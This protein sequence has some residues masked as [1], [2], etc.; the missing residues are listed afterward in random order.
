M[1]ILLHN[2]CTEE[3]QSELSLNQACL[4]DLRTTSPHDDKDRIERTNGGLLK[5]SYCWILDNKQFKQWR[6]NRSSSLLWIRGDPGKGKTMLLCGV[7]EELTRSSGENANISFFF[8][9][10]TDVR[11]NN[12]TAVLRG[13]IYSLVEKQTSLLFH[14][15]CRYDQAGKALF[16]DINAL[17]ALSKIFKDILKDPTLQNTYLV[18]DALDECTTGLPF[19]L[20]LIDQE[21]SAHSHV[22]WIV[23]SRNWPDIEERLDAA[24]QRAPISL[25]LNEASVSDA[26]RKFI[27]HK[28]QQL[29]KVKNYSDEIRDAVYRHLY[30]NSQGT[31]LW[32]ALVCQDLQRT[33]RLHVLRRL[34]AFPPGLDALYGRMIDQVRKSEDADL[35]KQILAAML[36][37]YRPIT[38][39][40]LTALVELPSYIP[41]D[42]EAF[43]QIIST[44]GSFL[45]LRENVIIFV[46]QSAKEFL[47]EKVRIEVFLQ[48]KEA[49]HIQIFSRSLQI[50]FKTLRRN[51]SDISF[52]G[53]STEESTQLG[54]NALAAAKFSCQYWVDHLQEGWRGQD[55]YHSLDD[56][57]CVDQF[58]RE[59]FLH[60]L[61][62]LAILGSLTQG[63]TAMLK[64]E[65]LLQALLHRVQDSSQFIRYY[66]EAIQSS[67]LQI[68][69]SGL[70]FSPTRSITRACYQN[71][72]PDWISNCPGV[73]KEW[74]ACLHT[75]EGHS[76][77]VNSITWSN[78]GKRLASASHD[79]T[80]KIWDSITGQC[81]STLKGH[82]GSVYSVC[83]SQD[84]SRLV[85]SSHDKTVRIWDLATGRCV[86]ILEGHS[87]QV[88]SAFWSQD[89]SLLAS[90]SSDTT[91]RI[92]DPVNGN[93]VFNL[94]GHSAPVYSI[95]WQ[96]YGR[97]LASISIDKDVRIWDTDTGE[98]LFTIKD[99]C[100]EGDNDAVMSIA[101]LLNESRLALVSGKM[102]IRIWDLTTGKCISILEG[103]HSW[104][105]SMAWSQDGRRLASASHDKTVR[106]WD[107]ATGQCKLI[108]DGHTQPVNSVAWSQDGNRL[109]SA[110][111]DN[112][113]KIWDPFNG[114]IISTLE[115]HSAPISSICWPQ[116][117]RRL[118]SASFDKTI[119][120][121]NPET[122][123]LAS[124]FERHIDEII[125]IL[126]SQDGSRIASAS[127]DRTV[128]I[129]DPTSGRCILTIRGHSGPI[130]SISWSRDGRLLA[131]G[132][133]DTTVGI[134][135]SVTGQR[136]ST[137]EGHSRQV[138]SVAWSKDGSRLVSTSFDNTVRIWDPCS[139]Q[140]ILI[141]ERHS[142]WFRSLE[143]SQDGSR[144][145]LASSDNSI[146][147]F[148]P[149]T[150][151][152]TLILEGH[153]NLIYSIAWSEDGSR[154]VSAS[155]DST[156][157]IW[158]S[159][160]GQCMS[161]VQISALGNVQFDKFNINLL[162]TGIGVFSVG[163][164][165]IAHD[166]T[167]LSQIIGYG[168]NADLTWVTYNGANL[169]WLP[170]EYRPSLPSLFAM[171]ST[172]LAI[173]CASGRLVFLALAREIPF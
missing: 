53:I 104:V 126:W 143:W 73:E 79:N 136:M 161:T 166:P 107:L 39:D 67:P 49:Q 6:E 27:R 72:K 86:L 82:S 78:D 32:V 56:G 146:R 80:V 25:E 105:T 93:C 47:L 40:E 92:W 127:F 36:V 132:S 171:F 116:N 65:D 81:A 64:L 55:K 28:V 112:T 167:S 77:Q 111:W 11:I 5:D 158:D 125:S 100:K 170:A 24:T 144:L 16:E 97:N 7:I 88:N 113:V 115:G 18:I 8:C 15:R 45:T 122:G 22:K 54:S 34:K 21:F 75:L 135:N 130:Y 164:T 95:Y 13:L 156:V 74:S 83:W 89:E 41:N 101:W 142:G 44:C 48:D 110:S 2:S 114:K 145:A 91:V 134:W 137:L 139:S 9:Q 19:L 173:S 154:L 4:R 121:W 14:V 152:C 12:A 119:R 108:L 128:R 94:Q 38:L 140:C 50:M 1:A 172:T 160:S 70:I 162:H 33:L 118:A 153:S 37:V 30:S 157:K 106:V 148:D 99:T 102:K 52:V 10:A 103:H 109:A 98:C 29:T 58:L 69:S 133:G 169:L 60:W 147:L 124:V 31:F 141:I 76:C 168:L 3:A 63:I 138:N 159:A 20:D 96:K 43:S 87:E 149:S 42:Y 85:S 26:V 151:E 51:I 68:Y 129:W 123:Q 62:G 117:E 23:S 61:E 163:S 131:S 59:K 17:S 71:E 46:H 165:P 150:G 57:G 66:R 35:C 90:A 155:D 84:G 120:I